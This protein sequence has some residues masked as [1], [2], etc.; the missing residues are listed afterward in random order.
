MNRLECIT[1]MVNKCNVAADIGTDHGYV[2]E[3]LLK[4][5]I[6]KKIIAT[7]INKGPLS[8]A[9]EYLTD[10]GLSDYCDFRLGN[11]L[12]VLE[13]KEADTIIIAGMGGELISDI[14]NT[15]K[16]IALKTSQLILQPMTAVDKL[17]KYLYENGFKIIDENIVKE[18]HHFY[19]I[20][21]AQAGTDKIEDEI[22]FEISKHLLTKNDM[23]MKEYI[24]KILET[25]QKIINN[26]EK[27]QNP[28]YNDKI[29]YLKNKNNKIIEV[30]NYKTVFFD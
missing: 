6:A 18:F 12:T 26:L 16:N 1:S 8:R 22:Y 15:S 2:A 13:E 27:T 3:I 29:Q 17:R 21:K 23:L 28:V 9:V 20:I 11:G 24:K 30:S 14:L 10:V 5:N 19:F 4:E 7:D 25:N